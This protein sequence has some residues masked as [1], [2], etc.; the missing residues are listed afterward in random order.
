[1]AFD[2]GRSALLLLGADKAGNW[3]RW[4]RH[5]IPVAEQLHLEY[6]TEDEE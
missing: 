5:N 2:P 1:L 4:Y 3:Q 6:T